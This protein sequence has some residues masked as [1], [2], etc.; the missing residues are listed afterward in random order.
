MFIC[1]QCGKQVG[2]GVKMTEVTVR[3]R[4]RVYEEHRSKPT[5]TEI[6]KVKRVCPKCAISNFEMDC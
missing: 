4:K 1:Q 5:G 2:P 3:S 6:V